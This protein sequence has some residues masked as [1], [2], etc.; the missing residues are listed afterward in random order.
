MFSGEG[1]KADNIS[2]GLCLLGSRQNVL[3]H[4]RQYGNS[5]A[6]SSSRIRTNIHRTKCAF[7]ERHG[8]KSCANF[9]CVSKTI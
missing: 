1:K 3:C 2:P 8:T 7:W 5:K 9:L 6:G 4:A